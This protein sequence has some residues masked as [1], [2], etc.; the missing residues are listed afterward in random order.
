MEAPP[1][2]CGDL[3]CIAAGTHSPL[4]FRQGAALWEREDVAAAESGTGKSFPGGIA[5]DWAMMRG[6]MNLSGDL[7]GDATTY[8]GLHSMTGTR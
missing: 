7:I 5:S 2:R 8:G 3:R 1:T 6:P 4:L